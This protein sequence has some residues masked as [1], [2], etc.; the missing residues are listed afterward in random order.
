MIGPDLALAVKFTPKSDT[1]LSPR[2]SHTMRSPRRRGLA[3]LLAVVGAFSLVA[4]ARADT[5]YELHLPRGFPEPSIPEDNPLTWEKVELG[6]FLFYDTRLS[7]NQTYACA[8]CHQQ[9][10][11]FTDGLTV[12]VGSTGELHPRS[13]MSLANVVYAGT[14]AWANPNLFNGAFG[15]PFGALEDQAVIPMFGEQPVELGLAGKDEE[16]FGRLRADPRY[17]R[18]FA[19]AFADEEERINLSTITR[20]IASFERTLISG[21]SP[22]DRFVYGLDDDALSFSARRGER[23]FFAEAANCS[24]C[25][26]PNHILSDS[27]ERKGALPERAFHNT[28]LYNLACADVGLP[29]LDLYWCDPPPPPALC[30]PALGDDQ[31][32]GCHCEGPG[33]QNLGCYPPDNTGAYEITLKSQDM[34]SFKAPSLRNIAV[35]GPYMHDGS[36]ATLEE[37]VEHYAQGG[38][39]ITEGPYAGVGK[40]SPVKGQFMRGFNLTAQEKADIVEFMEALTDEEFLTKPRYSDPFAPVACPG[41]CDLNGTVAVNELVSS[42]SVSLGQ[43]SLALCIVSDPSGNGAVTVDE[44]IR[45]VRGAL[46]GCG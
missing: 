14:L 32:L 18:L 7:G 36:I 30:N 28:G 13:S 33:P 34:G 22:Y 29:P 39:T 44:L 6:R 5:P 17:Q 12:A 37:V 40:D 38:R 11:A 16:L 3:L 1:V 21:N 23:L 9:D 35:T 2:P 45:A 8:S 41:D 42:V 15:H 10:K 4:V 20:A 19:E 43:S 26:L 31:P 25:H 27:N 24:H 46:D